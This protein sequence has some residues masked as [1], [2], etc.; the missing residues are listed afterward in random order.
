MII[1]HLLFRVPQKGAI[2]LTTT[3]IGALL[4]T[5]TI[6]GA[7]YYNGPQIPTLSVKATVLEIRSH[8]PGKVSPTLSV[9]RLRR[10]HT[11]DHG[12]YE[13]VPAED[14]GDSKIAGNPM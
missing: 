6:L 11:A 8:N 4:N 14:V 9:L 2:I 5:Y 3:H 13:P 10:Q 1:R 7:P 12:T